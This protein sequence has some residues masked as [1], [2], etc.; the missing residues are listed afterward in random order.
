MLDVVSVRRANPQGSPRWFF[1]DEKPGWDHERVGSRRRWENGFGTL[2]SST[3]SLV[4]ISFC[5]SLRAGGAGD[6]SSSS[7]VGGGCTASK[8][9]EVTDKTQRERSV[10]GRCILGKQNAR[11]AQ[12]VFTAFG[13]ETGVRELC[14][15]RLRERRTLSPSSERVSAFLIRRSSSYCSMNLSR[16]LQRTPP[17]PSPQG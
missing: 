12:A 15:R 9:P 17:L 16:I 3:E 6:G 7:G 14:R 4:S 5:V 8:H 13:W 11:V 1:A 2:E 10:T